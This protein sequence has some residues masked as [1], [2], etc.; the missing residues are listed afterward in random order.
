MLDQIQY[1]NW[2]EVK[3]N[4]KI[5]VSWQPKPGP[6]D[7]VSDYDESMYKVQDTQAGFSDDPLYYRFLE[8]F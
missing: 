3:G 6:A 1:L 7:V 8:S 2:Q 5:G 4:E